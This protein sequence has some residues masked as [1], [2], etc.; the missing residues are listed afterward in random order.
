MANKKRANNSILV[1]PLHMGGSNGS[2]IE[3]NAIF[4]PPYNAAGYGIALTTSPRQADVVLLLGQAT[5]KLIDATLD[6]LA[7]LPD[8]IKLIQLGADATSAVPFDRAYATLGPLSAATTEADSTEKLP[9][10][11]TALPPGKK[12]AAFVAGAPPNPQVIIEAI[13][14]VFK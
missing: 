2:K 12:I 1:F 13:L 7:G 14:S 10:P 8:H 3:L 5:A 4:V 6:L 9:F 11:G